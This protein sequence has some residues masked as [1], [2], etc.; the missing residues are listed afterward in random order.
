MSRSKT[1]HAAEKKALEGRNDSQDSQAIFER[2]VTEYGIGVVRTVF[3]FFLVAFLQVEA[4]FCLPL[5][6]LWHCWWRIDC[7]IWAMRQHRH[8]SD[9]ALTLL[10]VNTD[11]QLA[12]QANFHRVATQF[13]RQK[14][15]SRFPS[16]ASFRPPKPRRESAQ[17]VLCP[18]HCAASHKYRKRGS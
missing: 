5:A 4:S 9:H 1:L 3:C 14:K 10:G 13:S 6:C 8:C 15:A 2:Y 16:N 12:S 7:N 17:L 11:Q 18:Q